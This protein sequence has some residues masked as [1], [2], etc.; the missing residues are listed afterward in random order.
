MVV[1]P[2][3]RSRSPAMA[4]SRI[5]RATRLWLT[6][7][8]ALRLVELGG[9]PRGA[10]GAVCLVDPADP[11][12]QLRSAASRARV[13]GRAGQ[14][15]VEPGPVDLQEL[16]Q[17]LH[18]VGVPVVGDELEAAHQFVSPAKYLAALR[19]M[20]RSV[21]SWRSWSPTRPPVPATALPRSVAPGVDRYRSTARRRNSSMSFLRAV[22]ADHSRFPGR[23]RIQRVQDQGSSPH[24]GAGTPAPERHHFVSSMRWQ[25]TR[26]SE[27]TSRLHT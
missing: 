15:V 21:S 24:R 13:P 19:R 25:C 20:S 14:P 11:L 23:G 17:P 9:D 2:A 22:I 26:R 3:R 8:R 7:G 18:L 6:R 4:W 27:A 1:R 16:A 12:G 10:L 5:T